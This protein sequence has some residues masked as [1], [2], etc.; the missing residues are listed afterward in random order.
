KV[1]KAGADGSWLI[2]LDKLSA[3]GPH[4]LTV[5]GKNTL[6]VDDVLVG[7]V[8]LAS[9]QSNMA[10]GVSKSRDYDEEKKRANHPKLRMFTVARVPE[11]EPK[12]DCKGKWELCSPDTVGT[13]SGTAY[14]FGRELHQ[15]LSV[16]V[17]LINSSVG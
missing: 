2:K 1:T 16:P 11:R 4:T 3:A 14:F 12:S 5:R 13:F 10:M 15:K 9:G 7:E 6:T 8:W 17:G